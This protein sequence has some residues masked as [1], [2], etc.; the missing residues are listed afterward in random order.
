MAY[1]VDTFSGDRVVTVEDG[2]I[3][4]SF[5]IKLIGKNYAGYG[6]AQNENFVHLLENFAGINPPPRPTNGQIWYDSGNKK[7][8]F[9]DSSTTS[10]KST[11]GTLISSILPSELVEGDFWWNPNTEQ[12]YVFNGSVPI[13]IGPPGVE[14]YEK[15]SVD[16]IIVT[17]TDSVTRVVLVL[18]VNGIISVV[19]S[20]YNDFELNNESVVSLQEKFTLIKRGITLANTNST[21]G[22][23]IGNVFWG[24]ASYSLNSENAVNSQNSINSTNS[25]NTQNVIGGQTGQLLVQN[26]PG[27]TSFVQQNTSLVRKVLTQAGN[28]GIA[29]P[30]TWSTLPINFLPILKNDGTTVNVPL[31][32]GDLT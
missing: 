16:P 7:I 18:F 11:G 27:T 26:A 30:P 13:L 22:V 24:T 9:W 6:E 5:D 15:T 29:T 31:I 28:G 25:V 17:G 12:L 8:K 14:G 2:T 20:S 4:T 10:W 32:N 1:S 23:S 21:T 3:N 19:I